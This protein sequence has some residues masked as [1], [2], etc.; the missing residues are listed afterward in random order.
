[1]YRTNKN[2]KNYTN[3]KTNK[4]INKTKK[5]FVK[6]NCSP[7]NKNKKKT[8]T[9][10]LLRRCRFNEIKKCVELKAFGHQN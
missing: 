10:Y 5:K 6:L 9:V 8:E 2:H 3:K 4:I 7:T 1:M